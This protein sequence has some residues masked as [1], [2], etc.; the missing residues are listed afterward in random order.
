MS[1]SIKVLSQCFTHSRTLAC[2]SQRGSYCMS[3]IPLH[4]RGVTAVRTKYGLKHQ[5]S[6]S[7]SKWSFPLR[8][9]VM[10]R[11]MVPRDQTT[12]VQISAIL[13]TSTVTLGNIFNPSVSQYPH[14]WDRHNNDT[15]FIG[16]LWEFS[17]LINIKCYEKCPA[18][19][20]HSTNISDIIISTM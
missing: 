17:R 19:S 15:Y 2:D 1:Q 6:K 10:F 16:S 11:R 14:V 9:S 4:P 12:W 8:H 20:R 5:M 3:D 13:L 18:Y 7:S